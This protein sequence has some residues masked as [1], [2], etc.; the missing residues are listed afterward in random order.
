MRLYRQLTNHANHQGQERDHAGT[1]C[2]VQR[3]TTAEH[4]LI[5]DDDEEKEEEKE[6]FKEE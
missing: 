6:E 4:H 3:A 2:L 1:M 5:N